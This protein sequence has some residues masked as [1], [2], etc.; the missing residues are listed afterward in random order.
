VVPDLFGNL[1]SQIGL[2]MF[3]SLKTVKA[4]MLLGCWDV[5]DMRS[6]AFEPCVKSFWPMFASDLDSCW[7]SNRIKTWFEVWDLNLGIWGGFIWIH[8][9]ICSM[10]VDFMHEYNMHAS[11]LMD[12]SLGK[13]KLAH[14]QQLL[15]CECSELRMQMRVPQPATTTWAAAWIGWRLAKPSLSHPWRRPK[16]PESTWICCHPWQFMADSDSHWFSGRFSGRSQDS[17]D[18]APLR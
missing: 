18:A 16:L 2:T 17:Q 8:M 11:N 12:L 9:A 3:H 1:V 13:T 4:G 6:D 5:F 15:L 10:C 7:G 14:L